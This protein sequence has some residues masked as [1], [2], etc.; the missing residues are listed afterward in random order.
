M[1]STLIRFLDAHGKVEHVMSSAFNDKNIQCKPLDSLV[2]ALVD[3]PARIEN[4]WRLE[5][6]RLCDFNSNI[7]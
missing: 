6:C 3:Y 2:S 1:A 4:K 5:F 7:Q